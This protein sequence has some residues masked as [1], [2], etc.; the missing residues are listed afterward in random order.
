MGIIADVARKDDIDF[1]FQQ[2]DGFL[3]QLNVLV[4][5][6]ALGYQGVLWRAITMNGSTSCR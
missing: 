1:I 4:N 6:A 3:G 5:N 2:A